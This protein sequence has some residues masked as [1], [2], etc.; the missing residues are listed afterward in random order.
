MSSSLCR[1]SLTLHRIENITSKFASRIRG[2]AT[3][4]RTISTG[5]VPTYIQ[6]VL[7]PELAVLLVMDD[8]KVDE[9]E[10]RSTIRDSVDIGILLN[11]EQDEAIHVIESDDE[12][13]M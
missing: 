12:L 9:D 3:S 13:A 7:A 8:M 1:R 10:A 4:D 6:A 5:G 11:E 2:L